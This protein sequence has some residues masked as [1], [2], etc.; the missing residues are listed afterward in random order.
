M[1]VQ[2]EGQTI[3]F[4]AN[5]RGVIQAVPYFDTAEFMRGG[6]SPWALPGNLEVRA[7][8]LHHTAGWYGAALT[9]KATE[10]QEFAQLVALAR[11][12]VT[13][14]GI[15]PGYNVAVFPSGRVWAVGRHGTRR[16]HTKGRDPVT[17]R[18]WN[19]V[20]RGI[21][22]FGNF[23][24]EPFTRRQGAGL[25]AAVQD[26]LTWSGVT[27]DVAIH[28]HGL[29][30]TV[31]AAG[32]KYS[33]ATE[34]PG[35]NLA[36]WRAAGNLVLDGGAEPAFQPDRWE[37]GWAAGYAFGR[38]EQARDDYQLVTTVGEALLRAVASPARPARVP[39]PPKAQ[40]GSVA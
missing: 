14:F 20:G 29:I 6:K 21:V 10:S 11:D 35:A 17:R 24:V 39:S 31:D 4:V 8:V 34:C 23:S 2:F 12:H 1:E 40:M 33:Q 38:G 5:D 27:D 18:R 25:I 28:E 22:A 16:A 9:A 19:E 26:S 13:R 36:A 32:V 3:G 37:T 7:I 15:G 30:P